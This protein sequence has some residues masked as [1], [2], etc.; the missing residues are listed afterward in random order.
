M[1]KHELISEGVKLARAGNYGEARIKFETAIDCDPDFAYS[2]HNLA[3]VY[4]HEDRWI[5]ALPYFQRAIELDPT[6]DEPYLTA[7]LCLSNLGKHEDAI[8][9]YDLGLSIQI[10]SQS[11]WYN[12]GWA[13]AEMGK[14]VE[15]IAAYDYVLSLNP[16]DKD[17]AY[18]RKQLLKQCRF[19]GLCQKFVVEGSDL[20]AEQGEVYSFNGMNFFTLTID[21]T[22]LPDGEKDDETIHYDVE[23]TL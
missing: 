10:D 3:N 6:L 19:Q 5:E 8:R 15:A 20:I 14:V 23:G 4:Y 13:F 1:N 18:N 12:K 2:W 16:A 22:G 21:D 9:L 11:L 17:S 7:G